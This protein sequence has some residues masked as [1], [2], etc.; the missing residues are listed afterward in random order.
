MGI[1]A[2]N[3]RAECHLTRE[4]LDAF[5]L[6]SQARAI[7]AIEADLF[8]DEIVTVEVLGEKVLTVFERD[9]QPRAD[10]SAESL[11]KLRPA[12]NV[13]I[14]KSAKMELLFTLVASCHLVANTVGLHFFLRY[15][16]KM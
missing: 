8:R 4:K 12:F 5:A 3:N 1:T 10:T 7:H 9:Q 11:A 13:V 2:E 15:T 16:H 6:E 14:P